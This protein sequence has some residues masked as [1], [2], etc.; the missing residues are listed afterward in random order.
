MHW[1]KNK[2]NNLQ[3]M[4]VIRALRSGMFSIAIIVIFF[5][6]HGLSMG[7]ITLLQSLF[8][9]AVIMFELPTGHY[10]DNYGRKKSIV[11][12]G[13]FSALGYAIYSLAS[14]FWGFL[15]GEI[16]LALGCS[17]VSGAD[18][19]I[20]YEN[21]EQGQGM[22]SCIK[23]EGNSASAG[24]LS[25]GVTSLV[26]GSVLALVSLR[27]PLYFDILLALS[28]IPVA[29]TLYEPEKPKKQKRES[30]FATIWRVM[31]YS[32]REHVELRWLI[33]YSAVISA[34]TLTMVWFIQIY[35]VA[36]H[37]PVIMFGGLWAALMCIGALVSA[38]AYVLEDK[39]GRK[40]TLM[41]LIILPVAGYIFL[42]VYVAQWS[43]IFIALF[44]VVRGINNPIMKSY[45]NGLVNSDDRAKIL[46]VQ[47]AVGRLMFTIIGPIMGWVND[48][49]SL[50]IALFA[51]AGVFAIMGVIALLF[52]HKNRL[53]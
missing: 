49:Y 52:M 28:V 35:W 8:S 25:E 41:M 46:S 34:S 7:E 3:K 19:A 2:T 18:S 22:T 30:S 11:I 48:A 1:L 4:Y 53:L 6:E 39:F 16:I 38:R 40:R 10:A 37:I 36:A 21:T 43:I 32:L 47:S 14:T 27:F 20:I 13:C 42:G 33:I 12:G 29:L 31:K 44:Y 50:Q 24:M 5:K 51:C 17:F 9:V 15:A 45:V 26:G 23:T